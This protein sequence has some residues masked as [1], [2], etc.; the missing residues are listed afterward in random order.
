MRSPRGTKRQ[1]RA[2]DASDEVIFYKNALECAVQ[3]KKELERVVDKLKKTID[4]QVEHRTRLGELVLKLREE[5]ASLKGELASE[6]RA[7]RVVGDALVREAKEDIKSNK[8]RYSILSS[9]NSKSGTVFDVEEWKIDDWLENRPSNLVALLRRV[10]DETTEYKPEDEE[11][12]ELRKLRMLSTAIA[13]LYCGSNAN[14]SFEYG[15]RLSFS[16]KARTGSKFVVNLLAKVFPGAM[17]NSRIDRLLNEAIAYEEHNGEQVTL[18][19]TTLLTGSIDN[20]AC[21]KYKGAHTA[22]FGAAS[23]VISIVT[24]RIML[25]YSLPDSMTNFEFIQNNPVHAPSRFRYYN[26]CPENILELKKESWPKEVRS[27]RH[28]FCELVVDLVSDATVSSRVRNALTQDSSGAIVWIPPKKAGSSGAELKPGEPLPLVKFCPI[29]FKEF[30]KLYRQCDLCEQ[31]DSTRK[32][33][34]EFIKPVEEIKQTVFQERAAAT[35]DERVAGTQSLSIRLGQRGGVITENNF[36]QTSYESS[37]KGQRVGGGAFKDDTK[38]HILSV[39][40]MDPG[41]RANKEHLIQEMLKLGKVKGYC[42][43]YHRLFINMSTD[44]GAAM[45]ETTRLPEVFPIFALGH[46][47]MCATDALAPMVCSLLGEDLIR[48]IPHFG[49]ENSVQSFVQVWDHHKTTQFLVLVMQ[50]ILEVVR[51]EYALEKQ[52]TSFDASDFI[53]WCSS[54]PDDAKF[55]FF[56]KFFIL[57][58]LPA[59]QGF[60][61]GCRSHDA[62]LINSCRKTFLPL[63][64]ARR[65][66]KYAPAIV[67]DIIRNDHQATLLAREMVMELR[68][69][70]G[71]G[72]DFVVENEN[73]NLK[74]CV[75]ADTERGWKSASFMRRVARAKLDGIASQFGLPRTDD[76]DAGRSRIEPDTSRIVKLIVDRIMEE[77]LLKPVKHRK[78][79]TLFGES[80]LVTYDEFRTVG[81]DALNTFLSKV[82]ECQAPTVP[83]SG[84]PFPQVYCALTESEK[85]KRKPKEIPGPLMALEHNDLVDLALLSETIGTDGVRQ[86]LADAHEELGEL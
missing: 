21:G 5:N 64:A 74:A 67:L 52:S 76:N 29:C 49:G 17:Y 72:I 14:A 39:K 4:D 23:H 24:N 58:M 53:R 11:S 22:R 86:L 47:G 61:L 41:K 56:T 31:K 2:F 27:E 15:R 63:Y 32:M 33:K 43:D 57:E 69:H 50:A 46:E 10:V 6:E 59:Y 73:K 8:G 34:L 19:D 54:F 78:A 44:L 3:Q 12:N 18:N 55:S 83:S 37:R 20:V 45:T 75:T 13:C 36:A 35:R 16:I 42:E 9:K 82:L 68:L 26:T 62:T 81:T 30:S 77:R 84:I 70:G 60:R 7:F 51:I 48:K 80:L 1:A 79:E 66:N 65:R 28:A 38:V 25:E 40:L 85:P 71:Q